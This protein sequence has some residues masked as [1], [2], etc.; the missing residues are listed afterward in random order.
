MRLI[1]YNCV[2]DFLNLNKNVLLI[3]YKI[4]FITF[5]TLIC[6]LFLDL[7]IGFFV[8]SELFDFWVIEQEMVIWIP[9]KKIGSVSISLGYFIWQ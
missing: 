2:F 6:V 5:F 8:N 3:V 9:D 4:C 7:F 1:F